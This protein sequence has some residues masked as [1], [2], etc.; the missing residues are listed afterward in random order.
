MLSLDRIYSQGVPLH[1]F[2]LSAKIPQDADIQFL[3]WKTASLAQPRS[4]V[5]MRL[6]HGTNIA[7]VDGNN[8]ILPQWGLI[9]GRA[10][11]LEL[12]RFTSLDQ[13]GH[14]TRNGPWDGKVKSN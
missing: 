1:L 14:R 3:R 13:Q 6:S 9:G 8:L 11:P 2:Y 10:D 5:S 4:T 7:W 12:V